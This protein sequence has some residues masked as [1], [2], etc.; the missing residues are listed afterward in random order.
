M[1][2]DR[3]ITVSP[4][5]LLILRTH[6]RASCLPGTRPL[7][8]AFSV[9]SIVVPEVST[10]PD[11]DVELIHTGISVIRK[12]TDCIDALS[13]YLNEIAVNGPPSGPPDTMVCGETCNTGRHVF[14][15]PV[16]ISAAPML[17][18]GPI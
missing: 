2:R 1:S 15:S 17:G 11:V 18:S 12:S 8:F 6:I 9:N 7:A 5:P 14:M 13:V 10:L 3:R 16:A 4:R